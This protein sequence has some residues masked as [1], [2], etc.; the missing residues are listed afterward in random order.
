MTDTLQRV[1]FD[2]IAKVVE[3]A[4]QITRGEIFSTSRHERVTLARRLMV[5]L[6]REHTIMSYPDIARA[7]CRKH[8]STFQ[9]C[10]ET[11]TRLLETSADLQTLVND[12]N[13]RLTE[14]TGGTAS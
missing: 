3:R 8:H 12:C 5:Y 10:Y 11:F 1:T 13:M 4:T 2:Q 7:M 14:K 6:L 9:S